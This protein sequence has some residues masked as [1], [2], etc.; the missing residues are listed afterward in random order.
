M[1]SSV[2]KNNL[3]LPCSLYEAVYLRGALRNYTKGLKQGDERDLLNMVLD[4]L[5]NMVLDLSSYG[6]VPF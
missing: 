3:Y 5:N 4:R 2:L 1:E 6:N